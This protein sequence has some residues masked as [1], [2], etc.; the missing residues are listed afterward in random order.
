M[1]MTFSS[2]PGGVRCLGCTGWGGKKKKWC[3]GYLGVRRGGHGLIEDLAMTHVG[4][5]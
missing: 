4:P 3:L 2:W 1:L 5:P